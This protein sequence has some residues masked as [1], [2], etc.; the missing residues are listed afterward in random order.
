MNQPPSETSR[1]TGLS[2]LE[3]GSVIAKGCNAVVFAARWAGRKIREVSDGFEHIEGVAEDSPKRGS[4]ID[5]DDIAVKMMFNYEAESNAFAILTAMHR[6][7]LPARELH[8][9]DESILEWSDEL[10][11][12][13]GRKI[14]AHANVVDMSV[15]FTDFVPDLKE[16]MAQ[17][18]DALPRRLNPDGFGRNMSLFLVMK[19]YDCSLKEYLLRQRGDQAWRTSLLL[20]T[21]VLEGVTHLVYNQVAHRDL[22]TDNLLLDLAGGVDFPRLVITDFGCCLPGLSLPYATSDVSR[23]GNVAL[24][25]PEVSTARPSPFGYIDYS[26]ADAW[27]AGAIAYEIF[28]QPNPFYGDKRLDSRT[29]QVG[30]LPSLG[31]DSVPDVMTRLVHDL[32]RRNP[33]NRLSAELAATVCQLLLWA[34][35]SWYRGETARKP[36][37]QEILQWALTLATKV[38]CESRYSNSGAALNEYQ[39]VATLLRRLSLQRVKEAIQWLQN[40]Y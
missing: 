22:K 13:S 40:N 26:K 21:Q 8:L 6:E 2:D 35:S 15:A 1:I 16:A 28:G 10:A 20:L 33:N 36:S 25:A 11:S 30:H 38:I 3:I 37:S 23:G 19:R 4:K 29:Y 39:M 14:P 31:D 24:M 5:N 9:V 27:A 34:P 32:L 17:F 7:T 12:R 18:P